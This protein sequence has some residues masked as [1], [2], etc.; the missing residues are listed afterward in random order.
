MVVT[1]LNRR[2]VAG[3]MSVTQER[4]DEYEALLNRVKAWVTDQPDIRAVGLAGSW[5][6]GEARM[7]SDVDLV[8]LTDDSDRYIKKSAWIELATGQHGQ[9]IRTQSWG[10][11]I[12]R[13]VKEP[14]GFLIEFGFAPTSWASIDPLDP[15]NARIVAEGFKVLYDPDGMLAELVAATLRG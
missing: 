10:P 12:E 4:L 11:L 7:S 15:E 3:G 8:V 1:A 6:R 14:S 2:T 9:I 5:A 13:R